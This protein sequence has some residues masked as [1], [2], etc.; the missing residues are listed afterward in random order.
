MDRFITGTPCIRFLSDSIQYYAKAMPANA[1]FVGAREISINVYIQMGWS[2]Y[3]FWVVELCGRKS[4][5]IGG[6][7]CQ[8]SNGF[9]CFPAAGENAQET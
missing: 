3:V 4:L 5:P 8:F 6:I 1:D 9:A 7:Y 2:V